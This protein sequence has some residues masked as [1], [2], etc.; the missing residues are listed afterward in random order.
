MKLYIAF[1]EDQPFLQKP[2][3]PQDKTIDFISGLDRQRFPADTDLPFHTVV[4]DI[5]NMGAGR[6]G[7]EEK[8]LHTEVLMF[9]RCQGRRT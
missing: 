2:R 3:E 9:S 8:E 1:G 7:P 6:I 4:A 5:E